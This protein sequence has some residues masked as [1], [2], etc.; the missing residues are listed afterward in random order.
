MP[1]DDPVT[2]AKVLVRLEK[3][4]FEDEHMKDINFEEAVKGAEQYFQNDVYYKFFLDMAPQFSKIQCN[5]MYPAPEVY[6]EKNRKQEWHCFEESYE[7]YSTITKPLYI[8]KLSDEL[9]Q[10]IYNI[11]EYKKEIELT[12]FRNELFTLQLDY[13]YNF[14]DIKT[15]YLLAIPIERDLKTIRD[16]TGEHLPLLRSIRDN[17]LATIEEKFKLPRS[18][19]KAL[20]HYQPSF[21][22]L[23]I[24]FV[25][26]SM[27]DRANAKNGRGVLLTDVIEHLE[28]DS[29][30][31]KKKTM[32][33]NVGENETLFKIWK[34]HGLIGMQETRSSDLKQDQQ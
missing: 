3:P 11:L 24:H 25:H 14:S 20:F 22:H 34:E 33:C 7:V 12:M 32:T 2:G 21:Y 28:M 17:S 27:S 13:S 9:N 4:A 29:D 15:L 23:H 30:Y 5:F 6:I 19:I 16:L 18:Q 26:T 31:F 10:W 1:G 8:D